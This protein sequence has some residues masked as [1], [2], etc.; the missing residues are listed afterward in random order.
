MSQIPGVESTG[1]AGVA[2]AS[3]LRLPLVGQVE[4]LIDR[5]AP[6]RFAT[7]RVEQDVRGG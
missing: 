5:Y 6:S 2:T 3:L 1:P 4:L 7:G